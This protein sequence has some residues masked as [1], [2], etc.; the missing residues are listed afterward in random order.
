[1]AGQGMGL[2]K[3]ESDN[4]LCATAALLRLAA[5]ANKHESSIALAPM[6]HEG[7]LSSSSL[8]VITHAF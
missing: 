3:S 8:I 2:P 5:R 7:S 4:A 6:C 1:M